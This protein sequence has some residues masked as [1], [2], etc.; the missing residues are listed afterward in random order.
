MNIVA[1]VKKTVV[2]FFIC[3]AYNNDWM[4]GVEERK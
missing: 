1:N 2:D 3:L 4:Q